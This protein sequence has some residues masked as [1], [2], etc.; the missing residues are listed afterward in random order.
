MSRASQECSA[1]CTSQLKNIWEPSL[2]SLPVA[3]YCWLKIAKAIPCM[4]KLWKDSTTCFIQLQDCVFKVLY[5]QSLLVCKA[6]S[7][8]FPL[9]LT[10]NL[11]QQKPKI[12]PW[13]ESCDVSCM[14]RNQ[15]CLHLLVA[16]HAV[17]RQEGLHFVWS[18]QPQFCASLQSL[19]AQG[20]C[21]L[22]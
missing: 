2:S 21:R 22:K 14:N 7:C 17:P 4:S 20:G 13:H 1:T 5:V 10:Y 19:V 3:T 9:C 16:R 8:F 15:V 12:A 6:G 11:L 18:C